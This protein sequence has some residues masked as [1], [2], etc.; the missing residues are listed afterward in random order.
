[1]MT[2][3]IEQLLDQATRAVGVL[4]PLD[5]A[6]AVNPLHDCVDC[7]FVTATSQLESL[8]GTSLWPNAIDLE[9]AGIK[10]SGSLSTGAKPATRPATGLER[11]IGQRD[12]VA[13]NARDVV[14]HVLLAVTT[15]AIAGPFVDRVRQVL[16]DA[17]TWVPGSA[18]QRATVA[19]VIGERTVGEL[20][21]A[22]GCLTDTTAA[23]ELTAHFF[24][25][26]GWASWAKWCDQWRRGNHAAVL[27]P[28][29]F[30]LLSLSVDRAFLDMAGHDVPP[31]PASPPVVRNEVGSERLRRLED[32]VH[33][34]LLERLQP[35]SVMA[36]TPTLQVVTCID[37][38]SE[39]LRRGFEQ[40]DDVETFGLAGF[41]GIPASVT[42]AGEAEAVESL[43]VLVAPSV[44]VTGGASEGATRDGL[45][46]F[47]GTFAELTHEP[48]AMFALAEGSGW[49]AAPYLAISRLLQRRP[50]PHDGLS[51]EV[52]IV[53]DERTSIAEGA[54]RAMGLTANFAPHIL[55]LGHGA[56]STAN[57]HAATLQ[58]GAC[59]AQP[60][61]MNA[62]VLATLLND[63]EVRD[64]L[65]SRGIAIP[66]TTMFIPGEHNTTTQE[67]V[68]GVAVPASLSSIVSQ[69]AAFAAR[70]TAAQLGEA[71]T[72]GLRRKARD[73]SD[74][75]PEWGLAGNALFVVGPR[76]STRGANLAGRSFLHS[77]VAAGD[78]DGTILTSILAAPVVVAQ[79]INAAYYFSAVA[80]DVVG[81]GDKTLLNPVGDFAVI[82]GDDPDLRGGLP[83]QSLFLGDRPWHLPVR[84][85][86]A[87]EAPLARVA[88]V[89]GS[90]VLVR[91]LVEG[92]WIHLVARES[93]ADPWQRWSPVR[94]W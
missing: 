35:V 64:E 74:P 14:G 70:E 92:E 34:P 73:W 79:W 42:R 83:R 93:A 66:S 4:W 68:L 62:R 13:S 39:P 25:L 57:T 1:M 2:S 28:E 77:Y 94:G 27:S 90:T 52:T 51:G 48:S 38:R 7:D 3:S 49:L 87:V 65:R 53:A 6:I 61:A 85:M 31:L 58:C 91:Q 8:L 72:A 63:D 50:R 44:T 71:T 26:P 24:R 47:A 20:L 33:G 32:V 59:A 60:G 21:E 40:R 45:R 82:S 9:N 78:V 37:V 69:A 55:L 5:R 17:A 54:L 84:L 76:H 29:E 36:P 80:P 43:P 56:T 16:G 75:R 19:T 67:I 88:H 15:N 46:S 11:V 86:V 12:T 10:D 23:D 22:L 30:V 41:F 18:R 89:I 81:A